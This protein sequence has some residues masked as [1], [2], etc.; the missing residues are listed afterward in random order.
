MQPTSDKLTRILLNHYFDKSNRGS[1][2]NWRGNVLPKMKIV[3][4]GGRLN[5]LLASKITYNSDLEKTKPCTYSTVKAF[6]YL[7]NP[8]GTTCNNLQGV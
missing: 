4:L 8:Y 1:G 7:P 3:P 5:S 6:S 2:G